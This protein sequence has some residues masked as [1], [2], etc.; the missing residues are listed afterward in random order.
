ML[1][2]FLYYSSINN[3][4]HFYLNFDL[5][6]GN[7]VGRGI[8]PLLE[9]TWRCPSTHPHP[10]PKW[11]TD[12]SS[13]I[14]APYIYILKCNMMR[15]KKSL[16]VNHILLTHTLDPYHF[17]LLSWQLCSLITQKWLI[18]CVTNLLAP[19]NI[20][21]LSIKKKNYRHESV[22]YNG[23]DWRCTIWAIFTHAPSSGCISVS[24]VI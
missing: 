11:Q 13:S 3:F 1:L 10:V 22:N 14:I 6:L 24:T 8:N 4:V 16:K 19:T 15:Y 18:W 2:L 23:C 7:W 5:V 20:S 17:C 9:D 21:F 12:L